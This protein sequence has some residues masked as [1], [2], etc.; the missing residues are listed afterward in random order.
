MTAAPINTQCNFSIQ[1]A[2]VNCDY[3]IWYWKLVLRPPKCIINAAKT[4][5]ASA[6]K[7]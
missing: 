6:F 3:R 4:I 5:E 2:A 7:S 1:K